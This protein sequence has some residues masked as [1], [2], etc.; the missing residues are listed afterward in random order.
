MSHSLIEH[1]STSCGIV[2]NTIKTV[3]PCT[4]CAHNFWKT[5]LNLW[6]ISGSNYVFQSCYSDRHYP[7]MGAPPRS[8][9]AIA[10]A[11]FLW[12]AIRL[13]LGF[14]LTLRI[15]AERAVHFKVQT[16]V[17]NE[18]NHYGNNISLQVSSVSPSSGSTYDHLNSFQVPVQHLGAL[19]LLFLLWGARDSFSSSL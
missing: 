2:Q 1:L 11:P 14:K 3:E 4:H 17:L 19:S 10:L 13:Y 8:C 12:K 16:G 6:N 9:D 15:Q 7:Q 5:L 18:K